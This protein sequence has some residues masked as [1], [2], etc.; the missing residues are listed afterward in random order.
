MSAGLNTLFPTVTLSVACGV[1]GVVGV[2]GV[3][4]VFGVLLGPVEFDEPPPHEMT[5]SSAGAMRTK[6]RLRI[7]GI[8]EA[9]GDP[10]ES[11][12]LDGSSR[13][14]RGLTRTLAGVCGC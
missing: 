1:A 4:G 2:V 10:R 5:A 3:V 12:G 6:Y 8:L 13:N 9:E 11:Q 14:Y 7:W